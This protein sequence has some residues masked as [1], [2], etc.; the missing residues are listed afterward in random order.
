MESN[1]SKRAIN[2]QRW[3]ERIAMSGNAADNRRKRFAKRVIFGCLR[4][5]SLSCTIGVEAEAQADAVPAEEADRA[6]VA[7]HQRKTCSRRLTRIGEQISEQLDLVP[8]Q[9][10]VLQQVRPTMPARFAKTP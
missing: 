10:R 6:S 8:A 9:I 5:M 7:A 3:R 4:S 1:L 2:R